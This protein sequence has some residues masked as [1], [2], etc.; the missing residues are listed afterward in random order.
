[1]QRLSSQNTTT[2]VAAELMQSD[3]GHTIQQ[4][5]HCKLLPSTGVHHI[6]GLCAV[7]FAVAPTADLEVCFDTAPL[8]LGM[9]QVSC[10][11]LQLSL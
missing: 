2:L 7:V 4:N 8:L 1:M 3:T 5:T 9:L 6:D 11:G 10:E